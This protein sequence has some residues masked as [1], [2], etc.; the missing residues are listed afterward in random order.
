M[1][2][3]IRD[4]RLVSLSMACLG[5]GPRNCCQFWILTSL[6]C[7][8]L[9]IR[10]VGG[11]VFRFSWLLRCATWGGGWAIRTDS[12]RREAPRAGGAGKKGCHAACHGLQSQLGALEEPLPWLSV[13]P[14]FLELILQGLGKTLEAASLSAKG[15]V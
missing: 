2:T 13:S 11:L 12:C 9:T 14:V 6:P 5:A 1:S 15:T 7:L 4:T 10:G 8:N 3:M